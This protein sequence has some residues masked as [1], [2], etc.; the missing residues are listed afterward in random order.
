[1]LPVRHHAGAASDKKIGG[2]YSKGE[3]IL[4]LMREAPAC[5]REQRLT[6]GLMQIR[7]EA[8]SRVFTP[9]SNRFEEFHDLFFVRI[10]GHYQ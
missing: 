8:E 4:L 7:E 9:I 6:E 1:M 3:P 2:T 5:G 10:A